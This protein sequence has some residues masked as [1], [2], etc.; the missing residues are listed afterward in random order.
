MFTELCDKERGVAVTTVWLHEREVRAIQMAHTNKEQRQ[1]RV[2][3]LAHRGPGPH[4]APP[5]VRWVVERWEGE[6]DG[7]SAVGAAHLSV[8][9]SPRCRPSRARPRFTNLPS[10]YALGYLLD[11]PPALRFLT[12]AGWSPSEISCQPMERQFSTD[13][14]IER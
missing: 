5:R 8:A 7:S 12:T 9:L 3:K 10:A 2:E 1:R 13:E 14:K 11:A 4:R 6:S